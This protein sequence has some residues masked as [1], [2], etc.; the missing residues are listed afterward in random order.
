MIKGNLY[1]RRGT[2]V[3]KNLR[4]LTLN[5]REEVVLK[6]SNLD[7]SLVARNIMV[8]VYWVSGV[9]MVV[10]RKDIR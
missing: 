1:L 6:M 2:K 9:T 3:K 8:T 7:V 4:M 5:W 10:V